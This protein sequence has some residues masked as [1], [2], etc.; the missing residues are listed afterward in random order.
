MSVVDDSWTSGEAYEVYMGRW[1]R[2]VATELLARLDPP[3]GRQW[4][5]VGCGTGVLTQAVLSAA[6]PEAV[7]GVDPSQAFVEAAARKGDPRAAFVVGRAEQLPVADAAVD[8]AVSGLVLNFVPD[9]PAA[10][11]ELRRVLR[12]GGNAAAYVW[13]Y[14]QGM[15]LLVGFWD[16]AAS[17]DPGAAAL[18][19]G[20]RFADCGPDALRTLLIGAGF[21]DVQV[22]A[23]VVPT[24]FADADDLWAPLQRGS[25]PAPAYV[26]SLDDRG[27]AAL[28]EAVRDALP[29][30]PDGAVRLTARAWTVR[31]RRE[32]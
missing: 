24:V 2:V 4:L 30:D 22:D 29:A 15:Q 6:A 14:A 13:D 19:E 8:V 9:R 18:R 16:A 31:G 3:G 28:R 32:G 25:G 21:V 26:A 20:P 5:D 1:S 7:L 12:P 27:R 23:I 11:A 17:L 10:A